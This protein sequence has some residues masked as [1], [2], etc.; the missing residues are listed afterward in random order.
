M[1]RGRWILMALLILMAPCLYA[2]AFTIYGLLQ[3]DW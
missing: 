2:V 1:R 3:L